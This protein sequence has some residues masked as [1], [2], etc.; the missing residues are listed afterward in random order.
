VRR[1]AALTISRRSWRAP[2]LVGCY[3]EF[4]EHRPERLAAVDRIQELLAHL[5][6]ESLLRLAPAAGLGGSVLDLAAL[7]AVT[8]VIPTCQGA[9]GHPGPRRRCSGSVSSQICCNC[10][11]VQDSPAIS[12]RESHHRRTTG[13]ATLRIAAAWPTEV[14]CCGPVT[15]RTL[16][17]L[18]RSP[19][20]IALPRSS[21]IR[22]QRSNAS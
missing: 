14:T 9:V 8:P 5:G 19:R 12:P 22:V 2:P 6:R 21:P 16:A 3:T 1:P 4:A 18:H 7:G 20:R 10:C 17:G 11:S 13:G 15:T